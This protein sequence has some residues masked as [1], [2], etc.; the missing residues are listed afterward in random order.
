[1]RRLT[2]CVSDPFKPLTL[3]GQRAEKN[4]NVKAK[5]LAAQ[6]DESTEECELRSL[7]QE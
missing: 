1:M 6:E 5:A 3:C 7:D 4:R 2:G